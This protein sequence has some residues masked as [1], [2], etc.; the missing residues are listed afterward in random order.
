MKAQ[1]KLTK[2]RKVILDELKRMDGHPTA[3]D[4]FDTVKKLQPNIGLCTVYR[5]LDRFTELGLIK[6]IDGKL[7]RFCMKQEP[8]HHIRC[9]KCGKVEDLNHHVHIP[10]ELIS[11]HGFSNKEVTLDV[12]GICESCNNILEGII[13]TI[14]TPA[15]VPN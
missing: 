3:E 5:N 11:G 4:I 14:D 6:E 10:T 9:M 2:Q 13:E 7:R 12:T 8:H 15:I 1:Y